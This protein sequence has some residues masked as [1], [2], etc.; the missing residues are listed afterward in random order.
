VTSRHPPTG[1]PWPTTVVLMLAVFT[2]SMGFGVVLPLLPDLIERLLGPGAEQAQVSR[3]T[4]LLT[5]IYMLAVFLFAP[6]W[7]RLSDRFGRRPILLIALGG[8]SATMLG[9]ALIENL[10]AVYA[11]RLLSGLFAAAVTPVALAMIGDLATTEEA[12]ARRL[13]F[14]SLA[15]V[16]GFLLGPM[17]GVFIAR[18]AAGPAPLAVL[19]GSLKAPLMAVS[20]VALLVAVAAFMTLPRTATRAGARP[21]Q[22]A[23]PKSDSW[24]VP[25][26]LVLAFI[27]SAGVGTFEVGLALR[28]KQELGLSQ[29]SIAMMFTLCSLVMI[30]VQAAVF[31]PW[32]KPETTRWFIAPALGAMGVGLMLVPQASDFRL[33]LMA[34]AAVAASAGILSPIFTYW[35]SRGAGRAQGSELGKQ[36]AAASLGAAVGA[37]SGGWLFDVAWLPGA[38]FLFAAA[39][40]A[41]GVV[42]SLGLPRRL[43][44]RTPAIATG[45]AGFGGFTARASSPERIV[46]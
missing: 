10:T 32:I 27:V 11:E 40:A 43:L 35:I 29:Y 31:S 30:I 23:I 21:E 8:F 6:A 45:N 3:S 9:F 41:L 13:T 18:A 24:L 39:L 7:G 28:G 12:R 26:L 42:V 25:R 16:S 33:M 4:G 1:V 14:V 20:L 34:I 2:V 44:I 17:M 19:E 22:K 5:G 38:A 37:A 15:G 36:T 46:P